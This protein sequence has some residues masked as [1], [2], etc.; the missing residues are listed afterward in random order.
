MTIIFRSWLFN[1]GAPNKIDS[2]KSISRWDWKINPTS[3]KQHK[4]SPKVAVAIARYYICSVTEGVAPLLFSANSDSGSGSDAIF[5]VGVAH[6]CLH[7]A[8]ATDGCNC[9]LGICALWAPPRFGL[10]LYCCRFVQHGVQNCENTL[11]KNHCNY[12]SVLLFHRCDRL[13]WRCIKLQPGQKVNSCNAHSKQGGYRVRQQWELGVRFWLFGPHWSSC[14]K[15]NMMQCALFYW[16]LWKQKISTCCFPFVNIGTSPD[17]TE[18]SFSIGIFAQ[19]KASVELCIN[20]LSDAAAKSELKANCENLIVNL[21]NLER[22]MV[23]CQVAWRLEGHRKIGKLM[24]SIH[25]NGGR[26]EWNYRGISLFS[27]PERVHAMMP[28]K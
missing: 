11:Q 18:Q 26:S 19:M 3:A 12:G 10:L 20:K 2:L 22:R 8:T 16:D 4:S 23:V 6:R 25:K 17:R 1:K 7:V 24:I 13:A 21:W 27:L 15:I 5:K 9:K 28:R 14:Q